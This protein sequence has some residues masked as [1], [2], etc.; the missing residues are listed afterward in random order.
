MTFDF[1][2]TSF[3]LPPEYLKDTLHIEDKKYPHIPIDRSAKKAGFK[4]EDYLGMIQR[5]VDYY[6]QSTKIQ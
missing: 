5:A 2:N 3:H 4:K 1:V 6:S